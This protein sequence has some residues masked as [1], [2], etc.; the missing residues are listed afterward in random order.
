M[1]LKGVLDLAGYTE[2]AR[3]YA[4]AVTGSKKEKDIALSVRIISSCVRVRVH[5]RVVVWCVR[6]LVCAHRCMSV[7]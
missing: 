1:V 3:V 2:H 7:H 4:L 6:A 5:V